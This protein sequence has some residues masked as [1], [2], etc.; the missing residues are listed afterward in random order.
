MLGRFTGVADNGELIFADDLRDNVEF[1][2]Q[3]SNNIKAEIDAYIEQNRLS[4]PGAEADEA[5]VVAPQFPEPPILRL[6]PVARGI[7]TVIWCVGF[8]GDFSWLNVSG[9]TDSHGE[10]FQKS[11]ISVPGIYF[12]GLD[13]SETLKAG[14]ILVAEEESRRVAEHILARQAERIGSPLQEDWRALAPAGPT[15]PAIG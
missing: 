13:S 1:G 6:N 7:G 2:N 15:G 11:C 3:V 8:R 9:A 4:A 5:E 10:P 12:V 14:T